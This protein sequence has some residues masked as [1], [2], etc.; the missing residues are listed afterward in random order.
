VA[1]HVGQGEG[2]VQV[3]A[4]G[5]ACPDAFLQVQ[6][7][8]RGNALDDFLHV[9][10][11]AGCC[12]RRPLRRRRQTPAPGFQR[13]ELRGSEEHDLV[14]D[15]SGA[16]TRKGAALVSCVRVSAMCAIGIRVLYMRAIGCAFDVGMLSRTLT[17]ELERNQNRRLLRRRA[18]RHRSCDSCD[19]ERSNANA[20][21]LSARACKRGI[22]LRLALVSGIPPTA[23][24]AT[25][26]KVLS[27][28][29]SAHLT[30]AA[31]S[32]PSLSVRP[33]RRSSTNGANGPR[34]TAGPSP[35]P[36][37]VV[38]DGP[39]VAERPHPAPRTPTR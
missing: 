30:P 1:R 10:R 6:V 20:C 32:R 37:A 22:D 11:R 35:G 5:N 4:R 29:H 9:T 33:A 36:V 31:R 25:E 34:A 19:A 7:S 23:R 18:K 14:D 26:D 27:E 38:L 3:S 39:S 17:V 28:A 15:S 12:W 21:H 8:A 24:T 16:G 13:W 2:E